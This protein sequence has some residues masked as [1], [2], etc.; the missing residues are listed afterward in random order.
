MIY[1]EMFINEKGQVD[2][3]NTSLTQWIS[4]IVWKQSGWIH[5]VIN[6]KGTAA[7]YDLYGGQVVKEI[8]NIYKNA[9]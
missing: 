3:R 1:Q 7:F 9:K 6:R 2:F 4:N 5:S 8:H